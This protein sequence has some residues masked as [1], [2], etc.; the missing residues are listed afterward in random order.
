MNLSVILVEPEGEE[1]VGMIARAMKNFAFDSL[2]MVN[3]K[4]TRSMAMRSRA[5]H[6]WDIIEKSTTVKSF[7]EA[8]K[9]FD[10]VVAASAKVFDGRNTTRKFFT[11]REMATNLA[12]VD[13]S[14]ALVIGR[15]P[16]GLSNEEL[17]MCDAVVHIPTHTKYNSLNISHAVAILL[18]ELS[19]LTPSS[20]RKLDRK[21]FDYFLNEFEAIASD[22]D[23]KLRNPENSVKCFRNVLG[24]SFV[25]NVELKGIRSVISTLYSTFK[26]ERKSFK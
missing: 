6:S 3:P 9:G 19:N 10:F 11:V 21:E 1:N 23:L 24:R 18:Y 13:G 15:E 2:I 22:P 17:R 25:S 14:I 12:G 5:M 8:I 4:A 26:E 7:E 16:S 20:T